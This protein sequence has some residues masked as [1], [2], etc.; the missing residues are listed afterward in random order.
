MHFTKTCERFDTIPPPCWKKKYLAIQDQSKKEE[1]LLL[2]RPINWTR[3]PA[4]PHATCWQVARRHSLPCTWYF[5]ARGPRVNL[6]LHDLSSGLPVCTCLYV[7]SQEDKRCTTLNLMEPPKRPD[8]EHAYLHGPSTL[9]SG[10]VL[11]KHPLVW[12]G[13]LPSSCTCACVAL[14]TLEVPRTSG[15]SS[16]CNVE[17]QRN[18]SEVLRNVYLYQQE[19]SESAGEGCSAWLI[20][21]ACEPTRRQGLPRLPSVV[22]KDK[23]KLKV[24][25]QASAV[26]FTLSPALGPCKAVIHYF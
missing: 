12:L 26:K 11:A 17:G 1:K 10:D 9:S 8:H 22:V 2:Y 25:D 3:L 6:L 4:N 18:S 15:R 5:P 16:H 14:Y 19:C 21:R 7:K 24:E 13:S 20:R 23:S